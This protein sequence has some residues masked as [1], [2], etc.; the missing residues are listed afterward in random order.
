MSQT[1][2]GKFRP[3]NPEKYKGDPSNIVYR[4]SWERS[5]MNY[6]D[7]HQDVE[8]WMSEERCV[9]YDNPVTK[10]KARYF[11]DFIVCYNRKGVRTT[12]MVEIKPQNQVDGPPVNPKRKTEAWVNAVKTYIINRKKWEAAAKQCEDRGWN[13][14]LLTEK[15]VPE[16][17][18]T[19]SERLTK[20]SKSKRSPRKRRGSG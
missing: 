6:L 15:N 4:S 11:P 3:H 20:R 10:K 12:E 7:L 19:I 5:F 14:R 8:W 18:G 1:L 2:K 9:W 16:W 13:F 17:S